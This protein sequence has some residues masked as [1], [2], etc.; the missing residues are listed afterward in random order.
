MTDLRGIRHILHE[1]EHY[2][3]LADLIRSHEDAFDGLVASPDCYEQ[4]NVGQR[5]AIAAELE[6]YRS[7]LRTAEDD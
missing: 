5:R 4:V 1:G 7:W 3:A 6:L 2:V